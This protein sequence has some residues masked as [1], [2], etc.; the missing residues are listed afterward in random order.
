MTMNDVY[1]SVPVITKY[2]G[3]QPPPPPP[4]PPPPDEPPLPEDDPGALAEEDI[5]PENELLKD[6]VNPD[7]SKLFQPVPEYHA[8]E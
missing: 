4:P 8:G 6:D 3:Y 2:T 1:T 5:A 7:V